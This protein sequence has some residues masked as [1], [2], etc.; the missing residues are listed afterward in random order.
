MLLAGNDHTYDVSTGYYDSNKGL[1]L[2][3]SADKS[4]K[5][6]SP[7]QSGLVLNGQ[8]SSLLYLKGHP[9]LIIAGINRDTIAVYQHAVSRPDKIAGNK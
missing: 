5:I 3:G 8:V 7:A 1:V 2:L 9:S 6:L 4:F